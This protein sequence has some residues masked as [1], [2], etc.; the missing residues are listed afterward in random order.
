MPATTMP[1]KPA[2]THRTR[3]QAPKKA[4]IQAERLPP[5]PAHV[6]RAFYAAI[7]SHDWELVWRLGGHNLGY[8]PYATYQGMVAGYA[9]TV[10]DEL[11][12]LHV[13]GSTV[14]GSFRAYQSDGTV[15]DYQ[16]SYVVRGAAIVS[17][18]QQ[19]V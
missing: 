16:F 9:R 18:H 17:G 7:S 12:S 13:T 11:T 8:G 3:P 14:D 6:V 10:R 15:R 19:K 1:A 5:Q 2:P 4:P